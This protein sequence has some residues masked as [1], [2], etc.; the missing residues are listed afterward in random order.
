MT[1]QYDRRFIFRAPVGDFTSSPGWGVAPP[2]TGG[3]P[4]GS[5]MSGSVRLTGADPSSV[6]ASLTHPSHRLRAPPR[7]SGI[8]TPRLGPSP[9][10]NLALRRSPA[11]SELASH[12][13]PGCGHASAPFRS[14]LG[15]TSACSPA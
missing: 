3:G 15:P 8:G 12:E 6:L 4:T 7:L 9:L 10:A 1:G 11:V 2:P 13:V 5:A 14:R